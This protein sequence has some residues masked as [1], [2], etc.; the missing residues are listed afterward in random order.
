MEVVISNFILRVIKMVTYLHK[1]C[2]ESSNTLSFTNSSIVGT[3]H[4]GGGGKISATC[5]LIL[6]GLP[7][8]VG[9]VSVSNAGC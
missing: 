2:K 7:H 6:K 1:A 3:Q 8:S 4:H 5:S 9:I